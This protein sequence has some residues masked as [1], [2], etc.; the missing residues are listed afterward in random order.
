[1][2]KYAIG[3]ILVHVQSSAQFCPVKLLPEVK[4]RY[5]PNTFWEALSA[6][7]AV[8]I[9]TPKMSGNILCSK[10]TSFL[11]CPQEHPF[12]FFPSDLPQVQLT[13]PQPGR[14]GSNSAG[15]APVYKE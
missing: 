10:I 3:D 8:K 14:G 11:G 4:R 6:E 9:N 2:G 7:L 1:M 13:W 12:F 5:G 15:D